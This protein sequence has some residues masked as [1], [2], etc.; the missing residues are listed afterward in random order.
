MRFGIVVAAAAL[1]FSAS[2]A[3]ADEWCGYTAQQDALIECGY[4]TVADC[5]TAVGKGGTCFVDPDLARNFK[6]IK[7]A[8]PIL[9]TKFT[10]RPG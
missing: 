1:T 3:Q 9:A 5:T 8:T 4:T 10:A 6:R 2:G 7:P